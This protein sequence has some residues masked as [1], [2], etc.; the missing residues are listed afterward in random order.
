MTTSE[1]SVRRWAD[2]ELINLGGN[3]YELLK[4]VG[5]IFYTHRTF[6]TKNDLAALEVAKDLIYTADRKK[7]S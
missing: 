1:R 4:P 2:L 5:K 6:Y 3:D 7:P